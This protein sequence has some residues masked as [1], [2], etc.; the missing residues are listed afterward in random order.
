[1]LLG[2]WASGLISGFALLQYG[3]GEHEQ[4]GS[5]PITFGRIRLPQRRDLL[6]ARLRRYRAHFGRCPGALSVLEAGLGFAF[7]GVV[8]GY[9][10]VVY[11]IVFAARNSNFDAGRAR[12]FAARRRAELLVRLAGSSENPAIEQTVLDEVLARLGALGGRVAGKPYFLSGAKFFSIAT[13]QPILAGSADDHA[14]RDFV[15]DRR[16]LTE[17]IPGRQG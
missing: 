4:L 17:S 3:I 14:R 10:P 6:H 2:F 12:G 15:G 11:S 8:I 5:E 16:A 9:L 1:M 13:Q 7:L